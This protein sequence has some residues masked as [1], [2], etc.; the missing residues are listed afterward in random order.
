MGGILADSRPLA[1][2]P[3]SREGRRAGGASSRLA[4]TLL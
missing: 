2:I 3:A 1:L 4:L